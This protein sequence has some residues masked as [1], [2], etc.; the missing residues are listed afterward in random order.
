MR[1]SSPAAVRGRGG[2]REGVSLPAGS[3]AAALRGARRRISGAGA[4]R[5]PERGV[6]GGEVQGAGV[7]G[8]VEEGGAPLGFFDGGGAVVQAV[9]G[10]VEDLGG[11]GGVAG[12][13]QALGV[14]EADEGLAVL[15]PT[16][17][18]Q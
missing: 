10:V 3:L 14:D 15:D 17:A 7:V 13:E 18:F 4:L 9:D 11:L 1:D 8:E 6:G 12:G 5:H 16:G 2:G